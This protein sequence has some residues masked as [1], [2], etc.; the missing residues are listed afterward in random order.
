LRFQSN[1]CPI[2]RNPV[3]SLL[4]ISILTNDYN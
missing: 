2:C 1:K 3:E 4:E